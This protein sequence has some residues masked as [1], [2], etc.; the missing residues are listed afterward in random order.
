MAERGNPTGTPYSGTKEDRS[1][2]GTNEQQSQKGRG[3]EQYKNIQTKVGNREYFG[4]DYEVEQEGEMGRE[5]ART[6]NENR[7][8]RA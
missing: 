8:G 7:P 1:N 3:D 4:D 2:N 6:E 5:E